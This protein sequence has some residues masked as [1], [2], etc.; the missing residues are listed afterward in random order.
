MAGGV[1]EQIESIQLQQVRGMLAGEQRMRSIAER[2]A[3]ETREAIRE[4]IGQYCA[5]EMDEAQR[6][7]KAAVQGWTVQE[8]VEF[9]NLHL[10]RKIG[11]GKDGN[12]AQAEAYEKVAERNDELTR[13]NRDLEQKL[14]AQE[15]L[16]REQAERIGMLEQEIA[17]VKVDLADARTQ[18]VA[19]HEA[20]PNPQP[21]QVIQSPGRRFEDWKAANGFERSRDLIRL[22]GESGVSQYYDVA[23]QLST[24]WQTSSRTSLDKAIKLG[25]K[26]GLIEAF[27]PNL[28]KGGRPSQLLKLTGRGREAFLLLFEKKATPSELD[29]LLKRHKTIEHTALNLAGAAALR[30]WLEAQVD[31]Y[32]PTITLDGGRQ[33]APDLSAVLPDGRTIYVECER[34]ETPFRESKWQNIYDATGG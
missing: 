12:A 25:K 15:R 27:T 1:A 19:R 13:A 18:L 29:E 2:Q 5:V 3:A 16:A 9:L 34:G 30:D 26:H 21:V 8:M 20:A 28:G 22:L 31:M 32:P 17:A 33:F 24:L 7:H 14:A 23:G 10:G 4:L 11:Q 6:E